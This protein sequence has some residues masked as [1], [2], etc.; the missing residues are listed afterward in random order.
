MSSELYCGILFYK[1]FL[2][3]LIF[4]T[5]EI[6]VSLHVCY[7]LLKTYSMSLIKNT[8]T[9]GKQTVSAFLL[10]NHGVMAQKLYIS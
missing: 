2:C 9:N 3:E 4:N 8:L 7:K 5:K 1:C 6:I 10:C